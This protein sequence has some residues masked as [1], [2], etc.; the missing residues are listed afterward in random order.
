MG[1]IDDVRVW[2]DVRTA[3]EIGQDMT[4][5]L[6][7]GEPGLLA[8]DPLDDGEGTTAYD[9]TSNH[10]DGTLGSDERPASP[11]GSP[12]TAR[13]STSGATGSPRTR[14]TLQQGPNDLQN[15]PVLVAT[16]NGLQG[17]L[18]GSAPNTTYRID[19]Y[20]SSGFSAQGAGQ[21]QAVLGSLEVTTDDQGQVTFA[22]PFAAPPGLPEITAT[23]T[24]P[25]GDTSE[26]SAARITTIE[27]P[28]QAPRLVAGQPLT[29][30]S[31]TGD[32]I[33]LQDPDAGPFVA[34][35]DL[36]LS[37]LGGTLTL[38]ST[39][40]LTGSGDGTGSLS[41]SGPISAIDG[42]LEG[43]TF[44]PQ[45]QFRGGTT[46][47]LDAASEGAMP[48]RADIAITDGVFSVTTTADSGPGSLRQAILDSNA[49]TGGTNTIDFAIPG[50]GVHTILPLS[51]L[52]AIVNPVLID[53][54][55][56]PGYD[57]TPLI[58]IDGS[59]AGTADGLTITGS[60]VTVLG[61]DID[62][63][64]DGA[65]ILLSGAGATGD[66]IEDNF[67]GTDPTGLQA[68]P[69]EFGVRIV[70]GADNN[71]IGG[72]TT[73]AGNL[74]AFD[75]GPGVDVEDDSVGDQ[76]TSN[77]IYGDNTPPMPGPAGALQFQGSSYVSLPGGLID[78]AEPSE[79]LEAWFL[80]TSGG[81]ILGFQSSSAGSDSAPDQWDPE[82]YVGTDGRLYAGAYATALASGEQVTSPGPVDDGRW[83]EVALVIDGQSDTMTAYLDGRLL[84]TVP[85]T[86]EFYQGSFDQIGTG[87]TEYW[88]AAPD[89]WYGFV[90]EIDDVRV[91]GKAR[92]AAEIG[93]DMTT[94]LIGNESG[95]EADYPLDEGQGLTAHDQT[96]NGNDGTLAGLNGGLPAWVVPGNAGIDLGDNG[97]T[98]NSTRSS[99]AG[100][101]QFQGSS[102]VSLPGGLIDDAE[103]S[104]TLEAWFQ[105][106]SGG[107]ILGFQSSSASS[108][109]APDQWDPEIYVGTDG[110][111]YAGAMPRISARASRSYRPAPSTMANGTKSRW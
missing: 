15:F 58:E 83:H 47:I 8:D 66:T 67:I 73:A 3:A 89:G 110:R 31:A 33:A 107:V 86:P 78:D 93:Q 42:A 2:G 70:G 36:T 49:V 27:A 55:S 29:F 91:W 100:A 105:T 109:F 98:A 35:W 43:L 59:R 16:A 101:L 57:D 76:I 9:L 5:E 7:G 32:G 48:I 72:T 37:V 82:I 63:F 108:D 95:L 104:E 106:T 75:T 17:W 71:L 25:Q 19:V 1:E 103:P 24:D 81:V 90:G 99:T 40:G 69:D 56:Q 45:P 46:L 38:G 4:T 6:S 20:A 96:P 60:G 14:G 87:Y 52:P 92:T 10:N 88:A 23:A 80:T 26:V 21:A 30:S 11:P 28:T 68:L 74:I 61:L 102:Y 65:G 18:S 79:T 111:L 51:P 50:S 39:A 41:Y 84:G 97:I 85:G 64:A 54:S 22:I 12:G 13:P 94:E 34:T 77:R 62:R 44:T 53:G